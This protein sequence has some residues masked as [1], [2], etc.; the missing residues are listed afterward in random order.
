MQDQALLTDLQYTLV[1]TPD[2]G[3]SWGSGLWT[4]DEVVNVLTQRQNRLLKETL[5]LVTLASPNLTVNIGDHRIALPVDHLRTISAVWRGNDGTVRELLRADSFEADHAISTWESTNTV[6]PLVY[7]DYDPLT[8]QIQIAPA[9]SVAGTI[10]LLYVANGT[11]LT[12]NGVALTV[13]DEWAHVVK[14]G[15][16]ADLL[17]KDG[18]GKDASRAAYSEQRFQLGI[19]LARLI[20][21]GWS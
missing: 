7:M 21:E 14:Y 20:L 13:P 9:P 12:G 17:S 2:G 10:E 11:V 3:A 4:R 5:L 15:S 1:E 6:S 8:L 16:L 18:R 19:D